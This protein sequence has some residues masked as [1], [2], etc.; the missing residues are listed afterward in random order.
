[1]VAPVADLENEDAE[2]PVFDGADEAIVAHPVAPIDAELRASQRLPALRGSSSV[3]SRWRRNVVMRR[4]S[5][6][7]EFAELP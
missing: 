6:F 5:A 1:M 3:A 2:H 7:V 4:A